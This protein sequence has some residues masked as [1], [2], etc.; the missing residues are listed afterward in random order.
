MRPRHTET[1]RTAHI[2]WLRAAAA[3]L[4]LNARR[5]G[6]HNEP[7][8][9]AALEA[10]PCSGADPELL[11]FRLRH[12]EA[13]REA[14]R[15]ALRALS[16]RER[17]VLKLQAID[18]LTL[19]QI[20]QMYGTHKSTVSRWVSRAREVLREETCSYLSRSL[21][22]SPSELQS[23]IRAMGSQDGSIGSGLAG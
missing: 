19:D 15:Q 1:H 13:F 5:T 7:I 4:A 11:L 23:V 18:G 3:R 2:G 6:R 21:S 9:D 12:R 10:V 17:T 14:F 20:G 22:L 8:E 16:P